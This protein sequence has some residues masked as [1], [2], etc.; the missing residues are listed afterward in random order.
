[1]DLVLNA[2]ETLQRD[3]K[4]AQSGIRTPV[5]A[6]LECPQCESKNLIPCDGQVFCGYCDWNSVE[7]FAE[8]E[9]GPRGRKYPNDPYY[10]HIGLV[11]A[12]ETEASAAGPQKNL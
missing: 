10:P 2:V 5:N 3:G 1:M 7:V 11:L 6:F 8:R 9:S 12:E 4:R